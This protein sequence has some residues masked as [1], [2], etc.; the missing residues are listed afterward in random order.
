MKPWLRA[1][2]AAGL[3][4]AGGPAL[5]DDE[6]LTALQSAYARAV[7]PGEQAASY[8]ELLA[9]VLHRVQR[10]YASEVD[11]PAFAAVARQALELLPP[12][13]GEPGEVFKKAINEALRSLDPH[14]RYIDA[15]SHGIDRSDASDSFGGVGLEVES[16]GGA[17]RVVAPVPGS[18]AARAGLRRGDVILRVDEHALQGL[19]LA[20]AIA[21]LRGQPGT[22]VSL[23]VRRAGTE[24]ELTVPLI[25]DVIRR[26]L[27]RWNMEGDVLVLRLPTFS[28]SVAA[29]LQQAVGEAT[30]AHALRAVILDMRGNTGGLLREG[31]MT[32]DA[33]LSYGEITSLRGRSPGA[34]RA[35]Q[36]DTA[37]LLAGLP[38]VVLIDS[39]SASAAEL[40]AAALQ[41]NGRA[42]VMGQRSFGKGSVQTTFPLG[43][44]KGAL[45]LTTAFYFGP[46]GRS[47][48]RLGV[49]PDIELAEATAG[50]PAGK[51]RVEQARCASLYKT[52]D[53]ALSCAVAYL[54]ADNVE[55]FLSLSSAHA[56]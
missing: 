52:A 7:T 53:A 48:H 17:L 16:A 2:T 41:E 27:V 22:P 56:P 36:A 55:A 29:A 11:T 5:A 43:E 45:K 49:A 46:S 39:R 20:E 54:M 42:Q 21:R 40:V 33:F 23:T 18:P 15:R 12:G 34:Q 13:T 10:S 28:G 31:V 32:A 14:S 26:Q 50:E 1:L 44:D 19:A 25:R 37:E 9:S 35:W 47:V 8:R 51:R 6:A 24:H 4:L 30:A 38:M 3:L